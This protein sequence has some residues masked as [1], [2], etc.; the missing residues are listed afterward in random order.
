VSGIVPGVFV[1]SKAGN[2]VYFVERF[3]SKVDRYENVFVYDQSYK[4]QNVVVS[5]YARRVVDE[6]NGDEFLVLES[7]KRY[8]GEAGTPEY[9]IVDFTN[10]ALRLEFKK[11]A[12]TKLPTRARTNSE[13]R[14]ATSSKL[15]SWYWRISKVLIVPVL[16]IFALAL[17]FE[18]VRKGRSTGLIVAL[19]VYLFY[20]NMTAYAV[21]TIKKGKGDGALMLWLIHLVFLAISLYLLNRRN[22]NLPFIPSISFMSSKEAKS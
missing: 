18:D 1:E 10:Y 11:K 7:G 5:D 3:D 14:N 19:L 6:K 13:V 9:R 4:T 22:N 15:K 21:A 2:A 16:A 20:S 12:V 17:S 8:E